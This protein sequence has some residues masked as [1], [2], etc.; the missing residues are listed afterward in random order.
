MRNIALL[1]VVV[2]VWVGGGCSAALEEMDTWEYAVETVQTHDEVAMSREHFERVVVNTEQSALTSAVPGTTIQIAGEVLASDDTF[3]EV[4]LSEGARRLRV[5]RLE[6]GVA[7]H[8]VDQDCGIQ[9][10]VWYASQSGAVEL[11]FGFADVDDRSL[12]N[13]TLPVESARQIN[14]ALTATCL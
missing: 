11:P 14:L 7:W 10:G 3:V 2:F 4:E 9:S 1:A 6:N 5:A 12:V 13:L 8:I